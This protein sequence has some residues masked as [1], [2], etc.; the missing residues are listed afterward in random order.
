MLH[1]GCRRDEFAVLD[2]FGGDQLPGNLVDFV[3]AP[4]DHD[5]FQAVV[6]VKVNVQARIHRDIS[7]MLHVG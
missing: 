2:P 3:A 1:F 6:L 4:A 7:L 5:D